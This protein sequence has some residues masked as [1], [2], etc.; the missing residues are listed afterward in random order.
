MSLTSNRH[1]VELLAAVLIGWILCYFLQLSRVP[2]VTMQQKSSLSPIAPETGAVEPMA[3]DVQPESSL[4]YPGT[5]GDERTTF[6]QLMEQR[7]LERRELLRSACS[8][9]HGACTEPPAASRPNPGS[10]YNNKFNFTICRIQKVASSNWLR[11]VTIMDELFTMEELLAGKLHGDKFIKE[12]KPARLMG[13]KGLYDMQN[14]WQRSLN[15]ITVRHPF[16]RLASGFHDKMHPDSPSPFYRPLSTRIE[17]N[18]RKYRHDPEFAK[19]PLRGYAS[20]ED[21]LNFLTREDDFDNNANDN[22]W[23]DY[24]SMCSPCRYQYDVVVKMET[25]DDDMRYLREKLR[26]DE[27]YHDIFLYPG[28]FYPHHEPELF[29]DIPVTLLRQVHRR[30][31]N[32]FDM[33]GYHWPSWLPCE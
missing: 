14:T 11:A 28:H 20:F 27:A 23:L 32:D 13:R 18:Y 8:R 22:H 33:F 4:Q 6:M 30:Y 5:D 12:A 3:V 2:G 15:I 31:K 1:T 19:L 29:R 16:L 25:M 17:A 10:L 21:F 7:Q 26:I 9:P 24:G